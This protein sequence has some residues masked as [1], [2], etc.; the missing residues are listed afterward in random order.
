MVHRAL[1]ASV[2]RLWFWMQMREQVFAHISTI[3]I[4]EKFLSWDDVS[5]FLSA[6]ARPSDVA[7]LQ[8]TLMHGLEPMP[9]A[10]VVDVL[11]TL[12]PGLRKLTVWTE[13]K[14]SQAEW[15]NPLLCRTL[16]LSELN[17]EFPVEIG[18]LSHML[19]ADCRLESLSLW[20]VIGDLNKLDLAE[21]ALKCLRAMLIFYDTPSW[22]ISRT[23]LARCGPA[24][25]DCMIQM[26][27]DTAYA[28]EE[29]VT[30]A[31]VIKRF[32]HLRRVNISVINPS[33]SPAT[34][35]EVHAVFD[36]LRA[37]AC[38]ETL[39]LGLP[40]GGHLDAACVTSIVNG[41][42]SIAAFSIEPDEDG[43]DQLA[44]MPLAAFLAILRAHPRLTELPVR[45]DV[46]VLPDPEE[47]TTHA[48]GAS[49]CLEDTSDAQVAVF[50]ALAAALL[51][52]V[53]EIETGG[54]DAKFFVKSEEGVWEEDLDGGSQSESEEE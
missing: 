44:A 42:P 11:H 13:E 51:P 17:V 35:A 4:D 48:Y 31:R 40:L 5:D 32:P 39:H 23:F 43:E 53:R 30:F 9:S 22:S 50:C 12:A 19:Q 1:D 46:S 8:L 26:C 2:L 41:C 16:R 15:F 47:R 54:A 24:L 18:S 20:A 21:D 14:T 36:A 33:A 3:Y 29:I 52:N 27:P 28:F 34:A 37:C 25:R 6:F 49:I 7:T 45:L 10:R 38:L